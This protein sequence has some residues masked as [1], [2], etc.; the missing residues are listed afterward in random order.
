M[1]HKMPEMDGVETAR[2]IRALGDEIPYY[3]NVPIIALTANAVS[4][5]REMFM[6][7]GF[8]DFLTKPIDVTVL[9]AILEKWIPKEKWNILREEHNLKILSGFYKEG[10][11]KSQEIKTYLETGDLSFYKLHVSALKSATADIGANSLSRAAEKLEKAAERFDL[12]FIE[13]HNAKFLSDLELLL[14]NI[15]QVL[16]T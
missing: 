8:S 12:N 15:K 13:I 7:N 9:N 1:D 6:E 2:R 5:T 16:S 10:I 14:R 4:G 3:K 11:E